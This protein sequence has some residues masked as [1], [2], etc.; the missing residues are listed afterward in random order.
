MEEIQYSEGADQASEYMRLAV[1]LLAKHEMPL[2]P[3]NYR[4]AYDYVAGKN[5]TLIKDFDRVTAQSTPPAAEDL[6]TLYKQHFVQEYG[7]LDAIRRELFSI[8]SSLQGDFER[9][10]VNLARY[11]ERL[12]R[13]A[14]ILNDKLSPEAMAAEVDNVAA[15][16]RETEQSQRAF[17]SQLSRIV[18][19]V[20]SLRKELAQVKEESLIDSLTGIPNRKAFDTTLDGIV[21]ASR[22]TST[23]FCVLLVDIDHFKSVNDTYG[24][25]VG[26]KVLR[27]VAT[28]LKRSVK[29]KD[30]V[31]RF[32]GEEFGVILPQ[33]NI[34]GAYI[35]GE[36][37]RKAVSSSVLRDTNSQQVYGN[38]TISIGTA[39]FCS[40]DVPSTLL[41]R[42]DQALYLAKSR[43]RNRVEKAA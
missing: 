38:V 20:E 13:F 43:G 23:P 25:L 28:T 40:T 31:A 39:Q 33:T 30:V 15:H 16:T 6:H 21:D 12:G 5:Q 37:I 36:Q 26:D 42:A 4:I 22:E 19:E 27:F 14:D 32:G 9:S 35:V 3:L 24:H 41:E 7:A 2:S 34:A 10:G 29:G 11:S 1:T 18:I 8:I 17:E